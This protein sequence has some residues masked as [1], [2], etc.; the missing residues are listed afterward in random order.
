MAFGGVIEGWLPEICDMDEGIVEA[1]EY[2]GY[3]ED[4]LT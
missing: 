1:G 3:A 2:P 4:Q